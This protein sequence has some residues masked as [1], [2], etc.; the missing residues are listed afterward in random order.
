[1]CAGGYVCFIILLFLLQDED[2]EFKPHTLLVTSENEKEDSNRQKVTMVTFGSN[3]QPVL[4]GLEFKV[5]GIYN[6]DGKVS[7]Q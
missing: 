2:V 3:P 6:D 1:M 5:S 4:E 7:K